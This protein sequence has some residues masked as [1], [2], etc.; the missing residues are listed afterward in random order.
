MQD[1]NV[2]NISQTFLT[3]TISINKISEKIAFDVFF[4]SI[5]IFL[6]SSFKTSMLVKELK[7][8][9]MKKNLAKN[10]ELLMQKIHAKSKFKNRQRNYKTVI[11]NNYHYVVEFFIT[12][13]YFAIRFE[14]ITFKILSNISVSIFLTKFSNFLSNDALTKIAIDMILNLTKFKH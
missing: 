6:I 5:S 14:N 9:I 8:L 1:E 3:M 2:L 13:L 7:R 4:A 10:K 12:Y 11:M